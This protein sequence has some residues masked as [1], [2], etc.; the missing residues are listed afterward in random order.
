MS[1]PDELD[2][3]GIPGLGPARL[4]ALAEAGITRVCQLQELQTA[5]LAAIRHIGI[6]QAR[7]IQEHLRQRGLA[8]EADSPDGPAPAA[9]AAPA[10]IKTGAAA[11]VEEPREAEPEGASAS[12]A[13]AAPQ[14]DLEALLRGQRERLPEVAIALMDAIRAAAVTARLTR[15]LTRLLIASGEFISGERPIG[16]DQRRRAS[17]VLRRAEAL[18]EQGVQ[19]RAFAPAAQKALA[20]R[21]RRC[22]RQLEALL[23]GH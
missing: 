6:W 12:E 22:R 13:P 3:A 19:R 1:G 16:D 11:E 23:E 5:E 18:L 21:I 17:E 15:Q 9:V 2:L 8:V 10:T 14:E 7:R 20:A 4:T